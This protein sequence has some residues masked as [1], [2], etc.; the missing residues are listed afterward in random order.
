MNFQSHSQAGQDR[1]VNFLL[2]KLDGTFVEIGCAHPTELSNTYGLEQL[3]WRGIGLDSSESAV[4]LCRQQRGQRS[5]FLCADATNFNWPDTLALAAFPRIIDYASVDVD[6]HT[7]EALRR[8][9]ESGRFGFR[10]L[11]VEHDAYQRGD[12]LRIPNRQLLAE[13][14]YELLCADVHNTGCPFED[15]YVARSYVDMEKAERFRST[16]LDWQEVL[17]KGGAL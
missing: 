5:Q 1:F 11:T 15:W 4:D 6:E 7:H 14:G 12:R 17:R 8:L 16:G 9:V 10:V 3:G 13:A 2:Q